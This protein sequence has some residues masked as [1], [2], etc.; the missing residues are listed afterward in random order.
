M[1]SMNLLVKVDGDIKSPKTL[2]QLD[3]LQNY[4]ENNDKINISISI[5]DIIK[6]M[7]KS[8]RVY[9]TMCRVFIANDKLLF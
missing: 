6:Q 3:D 5:N 7:H 2:N 8:V 1:G 4:L 9:I